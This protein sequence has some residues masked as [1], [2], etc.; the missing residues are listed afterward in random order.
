MDGGPA[1]TTQHLEPASLEPLVRFM[2]DQAFSDNP[3]WRSCHCV[4]HYLTDEDDGLWATRSG[5]ENE[6]SLRE[7]AGS[8]GGHWILAYNEGQIVGYVNADLAPALRRYGEWGVE[9]EPDTG[10]VA[11]FVVHPAWRRQG[12]ATR[13]L[14][15][16]V[17]ALAARGAK[18][19]DAYVV[20]DPAA[21]A[22]QDPTE[23]YEQLAHH[24][25]LAMYLRAGFTLV[26]R[27][28]PHAHVRLAL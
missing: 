4:F 13:L 27:N 21:H 28:G 23:G 19:V 7:L 9:A 12:I 2:H 26:D 8:G 6:A 25:P 5:A 24:G 17:T 18:R 22:T 11:C 16:A 10:L 1:I 14:D 15:A 20:A 3:H